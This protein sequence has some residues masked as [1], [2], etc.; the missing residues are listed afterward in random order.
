MSSTFPTTTTSA[1]FIA[2]V[3]TF[4]LRGQTSLSAMMSIAK[5]ST[6]LY[7]RKALFAV[8]TKPSEAIMKTR[9]A[10]PSAARHIFA[11]PPK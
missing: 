11:E 4:E 2:C 3:G 9:R 8:I 7:E 10:D 1:C 5:P 6:G